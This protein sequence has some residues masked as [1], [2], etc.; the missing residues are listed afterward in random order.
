MDKTNIRFVAEI[1]AIITNDDIDEKELNQSVYE[2]C[3]CHWR[4]AGDC[5]RYDC[6]YDWEGVQ[7]PNY[8]PMCGRKIDNLIE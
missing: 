6:G 1:D 2:C 8:C 3:S 7:T 5:M 4:F